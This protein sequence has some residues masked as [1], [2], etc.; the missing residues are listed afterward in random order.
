LEAEVELEAIEP[1]QCRLDAFLSE[2]S[3]QIFVMIAQTLLM[4]SVIVGY[5]DCIVFDAHIAF[6]SAENVS[7][8]M[9]GVPLRE[10]LAQA[11][12]HLVNGSLS[13][14]RHSHLPVT[15]VEVERAGPMPP[16][17]LIEFEELLD[18]PALGLMDGEILNFVTVSGSQK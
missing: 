8:Q 12:T 4:W 17:G 10:G 15:D 5:E 16:K 7:G 13:Q 14:Q 18:M 9:G 2:F 11:L 1:R 3:G 6:Q